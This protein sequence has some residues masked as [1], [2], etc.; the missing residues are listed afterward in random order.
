M[1]QNLILPLSDD[2]LQSICQFTSLLIDTQI[3]NKLC[4]AISILRSSK[5]NQRD[6][7]GHVFASKDHPDVR[8]L[9]DLP[10]G[11]QIVGV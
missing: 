11:K 10:Y 5:R 2:K 4:K 3:M 9:C 1:D 8:Q 7:S 6:S